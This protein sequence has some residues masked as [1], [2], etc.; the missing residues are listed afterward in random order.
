[1]G[2]EVPRLVGLSLGGDQSRAGGAEGVYQMAAGLGAEADHGTNS[3]QSSDTTPLPLNRPLAA[4]LET[5][6]AGPVERPLQ[7]SRQEMMVAQISMEAAEV[8]RSGW[9]WNIF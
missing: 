6:W 4:V 1:M 3:E 7:E 5:V 2:A 8:L 9:T